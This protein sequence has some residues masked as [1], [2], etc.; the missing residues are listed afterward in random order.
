[1]GAS[2]SIPM[3]SVSSMKIR[4]EFV[5]SRKTRDDSFVFV[6]G[7]EDTFGSR[8]GEVSS[9]NALQLCAVKFPSSSIVLR[10]SCVCMV[11]LSCECGLLSWDRLVLSCLVLS[12]LVLSCLVLSC[13]VLSCLALSCL[14][15]SCRVFF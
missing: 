14:V 7:S 2:R 13:L 5:S 11:F 6:P 1:M 10:V 3:D 15:L 4:D 9:S 8:I 12:C